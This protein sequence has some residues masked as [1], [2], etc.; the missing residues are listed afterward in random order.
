MAFILGPNEHF[1]GI[2]REPDSGRERIVVER[3]TRSKVVRETVIE[4][5]R[6]NWD[7][8]IELRRETGNADNPLEVIQQWS[9]LEGELPPVNR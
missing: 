1:T 8:Q 6:L 7:W 9:S 2:V 4:A 3:A 5:G